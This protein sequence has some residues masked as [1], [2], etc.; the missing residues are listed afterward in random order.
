M[1]SV[2]CAECFNKPIKVIFIKL[3]GIMQSV[4]RLNVVM[5]SVEAPRRK[6]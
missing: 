1:L 3:N 4:I 6:R 5:V 2:F